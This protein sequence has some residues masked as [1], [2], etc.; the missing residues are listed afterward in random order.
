M[1]DDKE[2]ISA[3]PSGEHRSG[4]S[5][6]FY[7]YMNPFM[8]LNRELVKHPE[9]T[10]FGRV[11]GDS[12]ADAGIS[13]GDILVIDKSLDP[14]EGDMAVCF[15]DGE[16]TLKYISYHSPEGM[17]TSKRTILWLLNSDKTNNPVSI[18]ES[19]RFTVWGV[20]T[21]VIK[22]VSGK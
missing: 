2:N 15:I 22:K 3:M 11:T 6:Q 16:F 10:F 21:Y 13:E 17:N 8:D 5:S 12:M 14:K 4:F 1:K 18:D 19:C 20:V 7:D 9:A